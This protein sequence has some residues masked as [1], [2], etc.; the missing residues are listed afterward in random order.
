M[1]VW[2]AAGEPGEGP[3]G[4]GQEQGKIGAPVGRPSSAGRWAERGWERRAPHCAGLR[5]G[6]E[7]PLSFFLYSLLQIYP[8]E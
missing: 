2:E 6:W 3:P 1:G 8:E 7:P 4:A 5:A